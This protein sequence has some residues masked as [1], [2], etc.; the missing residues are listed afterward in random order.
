MGGG[1]RR[2]HRQR[3]GG[4]PRCALAGHEGAAPAGDPQGDR[5]AQRLARPRE[6]RGDAGGRGPRMARSPARRRSQDLRR[7]PL[8]LD[9]APCRPA[10][11]FAPSPRGA[12]RGPHPREDERRPLARRARRPGPP[13]IGTRRPSTTITRSSCCT[14]STSATGA[15]RSAKGASCST[16]AR[17]GSGDSPMGVRTERRE[18][19]LEHGEAGGRPLHPGSSGRDPRIQDGAAELCPETPPRG[20]NRPSLSSR[21]APARSA[22]AGSRSCPRRSR[23]AW[24]R[25]GCGRWD[26]R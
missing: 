12:A 26:I 7:H 19:R 10:R 14:A 9:A 24:R 23:R 2:A 21:T 15:T 18:E 25:A 5:R 6:P 20:S 11:R 8:L 1:A 4:D 13:T 3:R 17:R 16:C 22:C